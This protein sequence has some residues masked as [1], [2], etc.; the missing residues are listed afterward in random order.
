MASSG[1]PILI[2]TAEASSRSRS[3]HCTKLFLEQAGVG[4]ITHVKLEQVGIDGNGHMMMLRRTTS[5]LPR[6]W[7]AGS[8]RS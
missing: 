5:R 7:R 4:N 8:T 1:A 3:D 6:S 2:V